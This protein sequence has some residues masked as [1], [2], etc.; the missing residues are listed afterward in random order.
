MGANHQALLMIGGA[1]SSATKILLLHADNDYVDS[2]SY[3]HTMTARGS[4]AFTSSNVF[5]G[6][7]FQFNGSSRIDTPNASEFALTTGSVWSIDLRVYIPTAA[8]LATDNTLV[9]VWKT[10]STSWW[11]GLSSAGRLR[12]FTFDGT[13]SFFDTLSASTIPRDTLT[14]VAVWSLGDGNVRCA[15]AGSTDG[16]VPDRTR[17]ASTAK[18]VIGATDDPGAYLPNTIV[19]DEIRMCI[20]N[21]DYATS[22]FTPPTSPYT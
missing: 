14:H 11:L 17:A 9:S 6:Q 18:L 3:A 15:L 4:M 2:S 8:T 19:M 1:T 20:T 22:S 16:T 21:I 5:D 7:G 12:W 10:G 13:T